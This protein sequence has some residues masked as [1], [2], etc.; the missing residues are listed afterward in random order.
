MMWSCLNHTNKVIL[1]FHVVVT[2]ISTIHAGEVCYGDL[3]CFSNKGSESCGSVVDGSFPPDHPV[4]VDTKFLLYTPENS[5][6]PL[7]IIKDM[8]IG[9][10]K[11]RH[12]NSSR[13]TKVIVHGWTKAS[14]ANSANNPSKID[15]ITGLKMWM[16]DMKDAFLHE[17]D[18]NV[19]LVDWTG[20]SSNPLYVKS[21]Q[22]AKIA[23]RELG[24]LLMSLNQTMALSPE[25]VHM[26]GMSL[27]AHVAGH[28]GEFLDGKISRITGLDPAGPLYKDTKPSCR[29]DK[30]DALYV[31]VIHTDIRGLGIHQN[32]GHVDFYPNG[33]HNQ[34][35]CPSRDQLSC[36]HAMAPIYFTLSIKNRCPFT[37]FPCVTNKG[38]IL[39]LCDPLLG[40]PTMGAHSSQKYAYGQLCVVVHHRRP[41]C[42]RNVGEHVSRVVNKRLLGSEEEEEEE[43]NNGQ[44]TIREEEESG[45]SE[46]EFAVYLR[47]DHEN[48][49]FKRK[50][51]VTNL[52]VKLSPLR[53]SHNQRHRRN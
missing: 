46:D 42:D 43:E 31:D 10:L 38:E 32:I 20:G 3:G 44:T 22:N 26:I 53:R 7:M 37:S 13:P 9:M 2:V 34:P 19:I 29:L 48:T 11:E 4:V 23:G 36:S 8:S 45:T 30:K 17:G 47:N 52:V 12:L 18:Y 28:A 51:T 35:A 49:K 1:F 27:G 50:G 5:I 39:G 16:L 25:G 14:K 33:G 21:V 15:I 41:Y 6:L 24:S 40:C